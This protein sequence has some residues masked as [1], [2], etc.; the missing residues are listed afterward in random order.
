VL[1]EHP[2][3]EFTVTWLTGE[4]PAEEPDVKRRTRFNR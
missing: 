1:S 3:A 4:T 2:Q